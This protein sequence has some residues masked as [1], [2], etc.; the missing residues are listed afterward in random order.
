MIYFNGRP[1]GLGNRIEELI[2]IEHYCEKH[3]EKC[4]YFWN[5]T[6]WR[7]YPIL[8]KCKNILLQDKRKYDNVIDKTKI[9]NDKTHDELI[10]AAKNISYVDDLIIP[11]I[12]YISIHI[13]AT[14]KLLNR[15]KDEFTISLLKEKINKIIEIINKLEKTNV[16]VCSDDNFYKNHIISNIKH[17]IVNPFDKIIEHNV[18]KDFFSLIHSKSIYMCPKFS[19][20]TATA[21]LL[22]NNTLYSFFNENDT[23]LVRFKCNLKYIS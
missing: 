6:L 3:N 10:S 17:N 13:R 20:Y 2:H 16:F 5:N 21:S 15:G 8:I 19:S 7:K 23:T 18:Y 12:E 14:D 22:G 9:I 4:S 11:N 1:D